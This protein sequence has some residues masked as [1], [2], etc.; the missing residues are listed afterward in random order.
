[1]R[2]RSRWIQLAAVALTACGH[3]QRHE[4]APPAPRNAPVTPSEDKARSPA[5]ATR[6]PPAPALPFERDPEPLK[7]VKDVWHGLPSSKS[8]CKEH[9]YFPD[10]GM[11]NFYCHVKAQVDYAKIQQLAG[12]S[13][14]VKGPHT[15]EMLDLSNPTSFGHYNKDFVR[16]L[17][18]RLVPG[19]RSSRFR[20]Q[21]QSIYDRYVR[22]L[23]RIFHVTYRKL[24]SNPAY[25]ER[26]KTRYL[27]LIA[28]NNLPAGYYEKY[29]YFMNPGFFKKPEGGFSYFT[30]RGFDGGVNGNVVKTCVAFWIR[31]SIDGT[32]KEFFA[33]LQKL[34]RA[35]DPEFP[36]QG[37]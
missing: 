7:I 16:W 14:F 4:P 35:Y 23:A 32:D 13:A 18:E 28:A 9:D 6:P 26:E 3:G 11:R 22:P 29:F 5:R 33:G 12:V 1:M 19:G 17:S 31:R 37:S 20:E 10:G 25:L 15:K 36:K 34:L 21:T 8:T 24:G 27:K 2:Y 30:G